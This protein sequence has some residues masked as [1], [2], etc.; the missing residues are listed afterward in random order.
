MT[1]SG[2]STGAKKI[3]AGKKYG[4]DTEIYMK[5]NNSIYWCGYKG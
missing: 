5:P 1:R 2:K 3:I 4:K